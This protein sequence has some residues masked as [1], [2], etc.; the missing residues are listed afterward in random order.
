M[1]LLGADPESRQEYRV[2]GFRVRAKGAPR[3]V[4]DDGVLITESAAISA[5]LDDIGPGPRLVDGDRARILSRLG[6]AQGIIDAALTSVIER[7]RP[8]EPSGRKGSIGSAVPLR[9]PCPRW[10]RPATGSI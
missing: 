9:G 3:N 2:A 5:Y 4:T 6:L 7:R 8:A 10:L 1:R